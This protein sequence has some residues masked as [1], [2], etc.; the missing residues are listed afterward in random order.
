M[1]KFCTACGNPL[2]DDVRF[3]ERCGLPARSEVVS[4]GAGGAKASIGKKWPAYLL[5]GAIG[6][7]AIGGGGYFLLRDPSPPASS[8]IAEQINKDANLLDSLTCLRN[9]DYSQSPVSVNAYDTTTQA[10]LAVLVR[11]GIYSEPVRVSSGSWLA[12]EQ[13]Q[14]SHTAEAKNVIR[15]NQLCYAKSVVVDSVEYVQQPAQSGNPRRIS[16]VA[17]YHLEQASDWIKSEEASRMLPAQ[18]KQAVRELPVTFVLLNGK[19]ESINA[20]TTKRLREIAAPASTSTRSSGAGWFSWLGDLF[21]PNPGSAVFGKWRAVTPISATVFEFTPS[22]AR[23]DG[24]EAAVSYTR[25]GDI[26]EVHESAATRSDTLRLR[27]VSS[28]ELRVV[29]ELIELPL[30]RVN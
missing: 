17:K 16:G 14:Y 3:C 30:I 10:W 18:S 5:A 9:F 24:E 27:V 15:G 12:S 21:S 6:L 22:T 13:L 19:W 4:E 8:E 28:D 26:V 1:R 25:N 23:V 7:C 20:K 11:A 2:A 29:N